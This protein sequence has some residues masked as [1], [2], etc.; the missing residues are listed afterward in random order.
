MILR[1]EGAELARS[2]TP[3]IQYVQVLLVL[4]VLLH[5]RLRHPLGFPERFGAGERRQRVHFGTES[6][7]LGRRDVGPFRFELAQRAEVRVRKQRMIV[8]E[9]RSVQPVGYRAKFAEQIFAFHVT[10]ETVGV[11]ETEMKPVAKFRQQTFV[12]ELVHDEFC[13][14][15]YCTADGDRF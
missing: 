12:V 8:L 5:V 13:N 2:L 3:M 14:F 6:T 9:I 7:E 1:A 10:D 15:Q 4:D 11:R